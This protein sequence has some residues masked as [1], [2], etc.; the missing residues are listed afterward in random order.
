MGATPLEFRRD[1]WHQK[2]RLRELS[3]CYL[4][5]PTFGYFRTVP[6]CVEQIDRITD[7]RTNKDSI[8]RASVPSRG[9][10]TRAIDLSLAKSQNELKGDIEIY[11]V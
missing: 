4:R 11:T 9:K 6:A 10:K 2:T 1:L 3:Q 8:Y 7:K 5:H